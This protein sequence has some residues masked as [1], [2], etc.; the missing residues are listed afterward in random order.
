MNPR[1]IHVAMLATAVAA[2]GCAFEPADPATE[3]I[4]NETNELHTGG[5]GPA[6]PQVDPAGGETPTDKKGSTLPED[7]EQKRQQ[8]DPGK[9]SPD[10]WKTPTDQA[11]ILPGQADPTVNPSIR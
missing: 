11:P 3:D 9:P 6:T 1:M 8:G 10:P 2:S 4:G 5:L 7:P